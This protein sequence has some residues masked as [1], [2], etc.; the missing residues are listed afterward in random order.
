VLHG[1]V[2]APQQAQAPAALS[3]S[4]IIQR[5]LEV[6]PARGSLATEVTKYYRTPAL[7]LSLVFILKATPAVPDQGV[8]DP[9][10][11]YNALDVVTTPSIQEHWG[12][13]KTSF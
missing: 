5:L 13:S 10:D 6:P 2:G 11:L 8:Q 12:D 3:G 1:Q 4:T 7:G 9:V